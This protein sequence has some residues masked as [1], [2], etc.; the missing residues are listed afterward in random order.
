MEHP[1]QV[2][3][4]VEA[5][6]KL[7]GVVACFPGPK[8][9]EDFSPD[10]LSLPG[11]FGDLPQVA[12]QRTNGG[13]PDE[14]LIQTEIVF[15]R[16]AQ[17]WLSIEFLAWWVRDWARSTELIQMRAVA[18]PPRG[19]EIQFGRTLKFVIEYFLIDDSDDLS[20]TLT[21]AERMAESIESS[22]RLYRDCFDSPVE[23]TGEVED[24]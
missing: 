8:R 16:S 24:I 3:M 17:A 20:K 22:Y 4:L 2:Q 1:P 9:L 6:G 11:E 7:P 5:V 19:P 14:I 10:D 21:A 13:R 23:F 15:D 18:L 12:I